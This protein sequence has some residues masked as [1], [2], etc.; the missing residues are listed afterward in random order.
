MKRILAILMAVMLL[1]ALAACGGGKTEPTGAPA[2]QAPTSAPE[3]PA[4]T[5]APAPSEAPATPAPTEAP[6]APAV[7]PAGTVDVDKGKDTVTITIPADFLDAEGSE[8]EILAEAQ[9]EGI[10]DVVINDDG[11]ITYTMTKEKHEELLAEMAGEIDDTIKE[12]VEGEEADPTYKAITHNSDYSQFEMAVDPTLYEE[13]GGSFNALSF[14]LL[15]AYYQAYAG[16]PDA[17]CVVTVK[18]AETGEEIEQ[19][20]YDDWLLF[21]EELESWF[22]GEGDDGG[23]DWDW[24]PSYSIE[25]PEME[26]TVLLDDAGIKVTALGFDTEEYFGQGLRLEIEN[27]SDATIYVD[28]L[29]YTIN[30]YSESMSLFATAAPGETTSELLSIPGE[31]LAAFGVT[32]IGQVTV[33]LVAYDDATYEVLCTGD[34]VVINTS[35]ADK[36][37]QKT[38]EGNTLYDQDGIIIR[39]LGLEDADFAYNLKFY[40]ENNTDAE[41]T[42]SGDSLTVNGEDEDCWIYETVYPGTRAVDSISLWKDDMEEDLILSAEVGFSAEDDDYDTV[43]ETQLFSLP[44]G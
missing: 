13:S 1:L 33:Q 37:W 8:E 27:N 26:P 34:E 42:F 32:E 19:V 21:M 7:D 44:M 15:G 10:N 12:V 43:L 31:E 38:P 29:K 40:F 24:E 4:P 16:N 17:G 6:E 25:L 18:N 39:Y 41:I 23:W 14:T 20:T 30:G 35:D 3:T 36:D 28:A 11:S 22:S 5:E 2:T 9:E